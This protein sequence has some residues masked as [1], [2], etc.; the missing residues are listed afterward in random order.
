MSRCRLRVES[1]RITEIPPLLVAS[2]A[3]YVRVFQTGGKH[4]QTLTS[5]GFINVYEFFFHVRAV[6]RFEQQRQHRIWNVY[7]HPVHG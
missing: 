1:S 7:Y 2:R 3:H 5:G 6:V 4:E